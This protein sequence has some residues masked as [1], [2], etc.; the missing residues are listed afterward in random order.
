MNDRPS[1]NPGPR[2][3]SFPDL[4]TYMLWFPITASFDHDEHHFGGL[5]SDSEAVTFG[6]ILE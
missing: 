1:T 3:V 2:S 5:L 6:Y 4:G